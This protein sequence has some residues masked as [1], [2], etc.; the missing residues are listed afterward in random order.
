V[1]GRPDRPWHVIVMASAEGGL[2]RLSRKAAFACM[3]F[4]IGPLAHD[5]T[6]VGKPLGTT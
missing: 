5:P 4:C 6:R 1:T 3:E 2:A